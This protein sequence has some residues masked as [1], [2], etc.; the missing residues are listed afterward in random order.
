MQEDIQPAKHKDS[1]ITS[2]CGYWR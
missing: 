2:P 1:K